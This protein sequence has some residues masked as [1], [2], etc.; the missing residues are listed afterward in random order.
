MLKTALTVLLTLSLAIGGGAASVWYVL[1]GQ[2]GTGALTIGSWTA[3]PKIG[4]PDA[5]PY[6][7]ARVSREGVLALGSA[8]GVAFT[9]VED[10]TGRPLR[11]ECNYRIEGIAPPAR[12]WTLFAERRGSASM[13]VTET[14]RLSAL[15]SQGVVRR[16]DNTFAVTVARS[17]MSGNWLGVSGA[18]P[19]AVV[20][21]VYDSTVA[22]GADLAEASMPEI[23]PLG[24]EQAS[25]DTSKDEVV[26][27]AR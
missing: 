14:G 11:L 22:A 7:K 6:S 1:A 19:M 24:C 15:N 10:S 27:D 5:D 25:P 17:A 21:T 9:A 2:S 16:S 8:E 12:F 26:S 18:G 23:V 4:A 13:G 20:L 3:F